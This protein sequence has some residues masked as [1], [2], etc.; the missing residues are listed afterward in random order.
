MP[1][2]YAGDENNDGKLDFDEGNKAFD[3]FDNNGKNI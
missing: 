1:F 2:F 3:Y